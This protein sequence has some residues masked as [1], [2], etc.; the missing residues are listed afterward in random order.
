[1]DKIECIVCGEARGVDTAGREW[2]VKHGIRI[3]S[4]PADWN[5]YGK[6]AGHKRNAKMAAYG[7]HLLLIWNGRSK[8]SANILENAQFRRL[9]IR[10]KILA[11]Y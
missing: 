5:Q 3:E 6:S 11:N 1:M 9:T 4:F 2:A 10:E 8:G 7:S